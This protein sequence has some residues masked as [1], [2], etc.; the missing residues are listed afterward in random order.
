MRLLSSLTLGLVVLSLP[1]SLPASQQTYLCDWQAQAAELNT[2]GRKGPNGKDGSPGDNGING[3]N[4]VIYT[5]GAS[6]TLDVSGKDGGNGGNGEPAQSPVCEGQPVN[7]PTNLTAAEGGNGGNGGDGGNGGNA[8]SPTIYAT[9]LA[10]LK[11]ILLKAN[12]GK[13][14]TAGQGGLASQGCRCSQPFWTVETCSGGKPGDPDYRCTSQEFRCTDGNNGIAGRNGRE[15]RSGQSGQLTL[16]NLNKPLE[17]DRP[18]ASATFAEIRNQGFL[19]SKNTWETRQGAKLLFAEGSIVEDQYRM[20][21][22]RLERS[23]FM[24]WSA[25]QPFAQFA[26]RPVTLT[27]ENEQGIQVKFPGDIWLEATTQSQKDNNVTEF[28]VYNAILASDATRLGDET[29]SGKGTDLKLTLVDQANRSNLI[30]TQFT[31]KYKTTRSQDLRFRPASDFTTRYEGTIPPELIQQT[32]DR[33]ILNI[34][35]LPIDPDSLK[36]GIGIEVELTATRTFAGNSAT[37]KIITQ[38]VIGR[39]R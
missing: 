7:R 6:L 10:H 39:L 32:G 4:Q 17:P 25:P 13:G 2:F 28:V 36:P 20:L 8:G 31:L 33:F 19:L 37:Q 27:L 12:G 18:S 22:S 16:I 1:Y 5:D 14:G 35:K 21:V 23:F 24:T 15:G 34:G 11:T 29:L 3:N 9:N 38:D 26:D 30:A